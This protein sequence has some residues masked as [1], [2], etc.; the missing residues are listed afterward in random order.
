MNHFLT[1]SVGPSRFL[2]INRRRKAGR[3]EKAKALIAPLRSAPSGAQFAQYDQ[4]NLRMSQAPRSPIRTA[5]HFGIEPNAINL[6]STDRSLSTTKTTA[7]Q[8]IPPTDSAEDPSFLPP[9]E[10]S[11]RS[12]RCRVCLLIHQSQLPSAASLRSAATK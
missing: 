4:Q 2:H 10:F 5:S 12:P 1:D 8:Q 6:T 9:F 11:P 3:C 7:K